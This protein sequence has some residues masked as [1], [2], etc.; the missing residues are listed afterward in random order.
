MVVSPAAALVL[1]MDLSAL[2]LEIGVPGYQITRVHEGQAVFVTSPGLKGVTFEG[3]VDRVALAAPEGKHLFEVEIRIANPDERLRPGMSAHARIV[4]R[5]FA[6]ALALPLEAAVERDGVT[7]VFF[8][9]GGRARAVSVADAI[10]HGG[11]L[12]LGPAP[13]HRE[14]IVRGQRE[15]RDGMT[16]RVDNTVLEGIA[17]GAAR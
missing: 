13:A 2:R 12:V 3:V 7:V 1:F 9:D 17:H 6:D 8:A 4:T 15:L 5:S 11:R 10:L 16:V 14:L